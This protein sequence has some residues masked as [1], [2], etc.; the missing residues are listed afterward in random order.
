MLCTEL[1]IGLRI[2]KSPAPADPR[3]IVVPALNM[4]AVVGVAARIK[5]LAVESW[6][7]PPWNILP[8]RPN[9]P[10]APANITAPVVVLVLGVAAFA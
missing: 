4:L 10:L 7:A 9:P 8:A 3:N 2:T 1:I 5:L 6:Y